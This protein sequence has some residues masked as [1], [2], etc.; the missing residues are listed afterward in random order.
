M[1]SK[2]RRRLIIEQGIS[3]L[4]M[5]IAMAA[6]VLANLY[7]L[8]SLT[9]ICVVLWI[10]ILIFLWQA[11]HKFEACAEPPTRA[12]QRLMFSFACVCAALIV[13]TSAVIAF[14]QQTHKAWTI[15]GSILLG[16]II[17]ILLGARKLRNK[18]D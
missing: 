2:T 5:V 7:R 13:A 16:V 3:Q 11:H 14:V 9:G 18:S 12:D 1:P 4:L 6:M 8:F 10:P 15:F 17:G